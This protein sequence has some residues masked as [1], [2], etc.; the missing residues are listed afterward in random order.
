VSRAPVRIDRSRELLGRSDEVIARGCQ[1]HK[2]SHDMLA[3]GYYLH[4]G[5]PMFFCLTHTEQ[6][7]EAT[8]AAVRESIAE[9]S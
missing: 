1:G 9:L 6:D 2:R 7:I 4:P 8:I 3:R 5:H